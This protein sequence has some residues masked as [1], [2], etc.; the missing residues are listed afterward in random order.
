MKGTGATLTRL[1]P[2]IRQG[3]VWL[4]WWRMPKSNSI[5]FQG[6]KQQQKMGISLV[7]YMVFAI[8]KRHPLT[9]TGGCQYQHYQVFK[10]IVHGEYSFTL[11][12]SNLQNC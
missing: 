7:I 4:K 12:L 10:L 8:V 9:W 2:V 1:P 11:T 6:F 5:K 3:G